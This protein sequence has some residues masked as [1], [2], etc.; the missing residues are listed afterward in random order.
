VVWGEYDGILRSLVLTLK[1]GRRDELAPP[2]GRLLAARICLEDWAPHVDT[3]T[4]VPS[5][6][7]RQLRRGWSAARSLA[8]EIA[9]SLGLPV[10]STLRRRGLGRQTGRSRA[11]RL[12]LSTR[13]FDCVADVRGQRLL[14]IDDVTT[15]GATLRRVAEALLAADATA[16]F[17]ATA[18]RTAGP[19][20]I[21]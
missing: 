11:R 1:H 3:V 10:R 7:L 12:D 17:C 5:H 19:R 8:H 2:L 15:T 13:S 6:R 18:A 9:R 16:V 4:H 14:L 21:T 20:R